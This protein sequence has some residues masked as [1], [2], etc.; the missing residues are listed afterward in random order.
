M[1]IQFSEFI[2]KV[3]GFFDFLKKEINWIYYVPF[4]VICYVSAFKNK[5]LEEMPFMRTKMEV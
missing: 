5:N 3:Q 2:N 4:I 1:R